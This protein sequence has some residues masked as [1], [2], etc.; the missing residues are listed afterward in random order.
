MGPE[1]GDN[2]SSSSV[3]M[4]K[5]WRQNSIAPYVFMVRYLIE[6]VC[7]RNEIRDPYEPG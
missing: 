7:M 3:E 4:K 5:V 2:K 6:N 1:R